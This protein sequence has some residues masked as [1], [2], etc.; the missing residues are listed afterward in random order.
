MPPFRRG[1]NTLGKRL[2]SFSNVN[3]APRFAKL[4]SAGFRFNSSQNCVE[5]HFCYTRDYNFLSTRDPNVFHAK[6]CPDCMYLRRKVGDLW[7]D[8]VV[9][10]SYRDYDEELFLCKICY[11]K[12]IFCIFKPCGHAVC[13]NVCFFSLNKCPYCKIPIYAYQRIYY[14]ITRNIT[15]KIRKTVYLLYL[16]SLYFTYIELCNN[17]FITQSH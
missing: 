8:N 1:Y 10:N 6:T 13:C 5:C 16:Y 15:Q 17:V 14:W 12:K 7:I 3:L 2:E 11:L 9:N 4:A